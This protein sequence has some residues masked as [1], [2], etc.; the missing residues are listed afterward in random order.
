MY[1]FVST[2][3]FPVSTGKYP[4]STLGG[5]S[6]GPSGA[7]Y[8]EKPSTFVG[9]SVDIF[10]YTPVCTFVSTF[11]GQISRVKFRGSRALCLS[12]KR[13]P[14]QTGTKMPIF[15]NPGPF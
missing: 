10:V 13:A 1:I 7:F 2:G 8:T 6:V 3:K 4:V 5:V 11:V 9:I 12:D 14:K 15:H